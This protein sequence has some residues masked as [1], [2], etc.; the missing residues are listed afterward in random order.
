[1]IQNTDVTLNT[2]KTEH[3]TQFNHDANYA[4]LKKFIKF[5]LPAMNDFIPKSP[6]LYN[7]FYEEQTEINDMR[8]YETQQRPSSQTILTLE[9]LQKNFPTPSLTIRANKILLH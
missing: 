7:Y 6:I 3:F 2:N 1:M 4:K 5:S 8:L 9:T